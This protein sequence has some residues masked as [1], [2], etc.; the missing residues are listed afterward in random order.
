LMRDPQT[1]A[2]SLSEGQ[3]RLISGIGTYFVQ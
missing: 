1:T 2:R 3:R